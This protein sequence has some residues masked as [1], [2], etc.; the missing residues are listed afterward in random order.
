MSQTTSYAYTA[1]GDLTS[2]EEPLNKVTTF[3]NDAIGRRISA[4]DSEGYTVLAEYDNFDRPTKVTYPDGTNDIL[5]YNLLDLVATTDRNGR[6]ATFQFDASQ[7]LTQVTDPKGGLTLLGYGAS[8]NP[9]SLTDPGGRVTSFGYDVQSRPVL[10]QY[11]GGA[12]ESYTY[13]LCCGLP[14]TVTDAL[15][16]SKTMSYNLDNTLKGVTYSGSTPGVTYNYDTVLPRVVSMTDGTGQTTMTYGAFGSPGANQVASIS[17][18]YGDSA[19]FTYDVAGRP[20][21]QT[22]N[23][24]AENV[25]YDDLWRPTS[26]TN[27][28]DTFNMTYLGKTGQVTG[29]NSTAGPS[30]AY[31]YGTNAQDRRLT[32]IKNLG[33]AGDALSQFD[34]QYD[35][36]G[37]I[38]KLTETVG[39]GNTT[40]GGGGD[41]CHD[42][43]CHKGKCCKKNKCCKKKCCKG[44]G[45]CGKSHCNK[46]HNDE[47]DDD[48]RYGLAAPFDLRLLNGLLGVGIASLWGGLLWQFARRPRTTTSRLAQV[49]SAALISALALNGCIFSGG[50][51]TTA[52]T[53]VYDFT[54]DRLGQLIGVDLN[55]TAQE[56]YVFDDSGNL[57]SLTVGNTTTSFAANSLN[58]QTAPGTHVY[59]AKGQK[60]TLDGKTFEWDDQGRVTA[61][62]QGTTR[63]EFA[64]DG[65]SRRTKITELSNGTVT[66]K[67]LYFWL[68]GTIVC[69]RDGLVSGFPI[70][71]QYFGQG[72]V[73]GATKLYYAMDH[74][75][76]IREL[77]DSAGTVQAEYRYSTYGERTK[78]SGNLESDWGYAGL[79][80]HQ[81]SGL[82]LATYRLYD[83]ANKRWISRDPLGEGVDYNLY[84][85]CGNNPINWRDPA[86]LDR[87]L[88]YFTLFEQGITQDGDSIY[89]NWDLRLSTSNGEDSLGGASLIHT[90][91]V[92][93][94]KGWVKVGTDRQETGPMKN[95]E[96]RRLKFQIKPWACDGIPKA[97][98]IKV[99]TE[100]DG[101]KK[102]YSRESEYTIELGLKYRAYRVQNDRT[103]PEIWQ[104]SW[105]IDRN[106]RN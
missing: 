55:Q 66:S 70:T 43:C 47:D 78:T 22:V 59:D 93:S 21:S 67:K 94:A 85:Y 57:T 80:H 25:T 20:Q 6:R 64:Y 61:I 5:E 86:G 100:L 99:I 83:A 23:G 31:T 27:A 39:A 63:S 106:S 104:D 101:G 105:R 95:R 19:T 18:P 15:G 38:T 45:D 54:Y 49:T 52:T 36:V 87:H 1:D 89:F 81:A 82:D 77:V 3:T 84:R 60:T 74:L 50:G 98:A 29:V 96:V 30:M 32:Q 88:E 26:S 8:N 14:R 69:E 71:K 103:I 65:M 11:A 4:T 76:S 41:P 102:T 56:R 91:Y 13:M 72:E 92:P 97:I 33:R 28:L 2:I 7:R 35:A 24:S 90:L 16:H 79:W 73:R 40:G 17:G 34:Y 10:K 68:G 9:T 48:D 58:Q 37:Q 12:S 42:K 51:A 75:G 44:K 62:V 46:R 53:N